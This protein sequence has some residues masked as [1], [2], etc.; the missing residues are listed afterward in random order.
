VLYSAGAGRFDVVAQPGPQGLRLAALAEAA[1]PEWARAWE[2]PT[3]YSTAITA[4]LVPTEQ[5]SFKDA[6]WRV[7]DDAGG[8]VTVWLRGAAEGEMET[9]ELARE[10]RWLTGLA[11]A[12]LRRQALQ[13]G[14][15]P[16]R[17]VVP[18]W[19]AAGAAEA[20]LIAEQPALLDAWQL[21][22][23]GA[24]H[25]PSLRAILLSADALTEREQSAAYG[26]WLWL[27][28]ASG[29]EPGWRRFV[30]A[31][32]GGETAGAALAREL[33][34]LVTKPADAREWELAWRVATA[35]LAGT[36]VTP[37]ADAAETR[38]WVE[39]LSRI[40]ARDA[41]SGGE[42]AVSAAGDWAERREPWLS[43]ERSRRAD[44]LAR[45]LTRLHPFYRNAAGSLGRAWLAL[46]NGTEAEWRAAER[47]WLAD[48][49]TGRALEEASKQ[50]LDE[51]AAR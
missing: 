33:G 2:L 9:S 19:L 31:L 20:V 22:V 47:D 36:R 27:R 16:E 1:W 21:R 37:V 29:R 10:R 3:R 46:A 42:R 15:A 49:A 5:W 28:E 38:R 50:L 51:V 26:V 40:V 30:A 18:A 23:H 25:G 24:E 32:L 41:A 14:F 35:R 13:L 44:L 12:V 39:Q 48:W 34:G 11:A 4:R 7:V 43:E 8:L 17:S 45:E 6:E